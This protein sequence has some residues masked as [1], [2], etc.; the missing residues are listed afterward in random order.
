MGKMFKISSETASI[1]KNR[2]FLLIFRLFGKVVGP[3]DFPTGEG[4]NAP[5]EPPLQRGGTS[6]LWD[7]PGRIFLVPNRAEKTLI[8]LTVIFW[9]EI[10]Q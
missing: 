3:P 9:S 7:P 10:S 1:F 2:A 6:P 4:A 8:F 5:F